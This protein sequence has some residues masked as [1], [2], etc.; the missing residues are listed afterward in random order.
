M[1]GINMFC[2]LAHWERDSNNSHR[3]TWKGKY[4]IGARMQNYAIG[5]LL[6]QIES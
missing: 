1:G 3:L 2:N 4:A 5:N 6:T